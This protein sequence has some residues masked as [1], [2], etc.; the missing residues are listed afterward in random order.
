MPSARGWRRTLAETYHIP[1]RPQLRQVD[2][3]LLALVVVAV[4][5]GL[6]AIFS[7]SFE[8]AQAMF[9]NGAHFVIRQLVGILGGAAAALVVMTQVRKSL[10]I[11]SR[12][13]FWAVIGLLV[14][15]PFVGKSVKG[16][17]RWIDL[18]PINVQPSELAKL[19]VIAFL[20]DF[21]ARNAGQLQRRAVFMPALLIVAG[22]IFLIAIQR[23][24]G[25][26]VV[27]VM[28][29]APIL[30]AAGLPKRVFAGLAGV[31]AAFVAIMIAM[32]PYR[33]RR[34]TSFVD[35]FAVLEEGGYQVVQGWASMASGGLSGLGFGTGLASQGYLPEA[36]TDFIS[37]VIAEEFGAIG[38]VVLVL[39]FVGM[40]ARGLRIVE[41]APD[42]R[43]ALLALGITSLIGAQAVV[44]MG[45]VAGLMPPKGLVLPFVSYGA[46]A[47][48]VYTLAIGILLRVGMEAPPEAPSA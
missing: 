27:I 45:V 14:A 38:W 35:P 33:L 29:T 12:R 31:V 30:I 48:A 44:N 34:V 1:S 46:T 9:N 28:T 3:T 4:L 11:W 40:L 13:F 20:V 15:V 17:Q 22:P 10:V 6:A 19:A 41:R 5:M 7:A 8:G 32:E 18:G 16:A 39:L 24:L 42:M 25:T 37:A 43:G 2:K 23:D 26:C 36:H 47:A 21:L